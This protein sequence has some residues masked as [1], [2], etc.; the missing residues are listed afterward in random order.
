MGICGSTKKEEKEYEEY[1]RKATQ[2][3]VNI[4]LPKIEKQTSIMAN[5]FPPGA[6]FLD[7]RQKK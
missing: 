1:K 3:K 2:V 5:K 4:P 6:C 7:N